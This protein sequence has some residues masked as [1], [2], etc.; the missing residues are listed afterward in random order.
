MVEFDTPDVLLSNGASCFAA[1]VEQTG[2][3]EAE[4]L[5][6]LTKRKRMA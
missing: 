3:A 6:L 5:Q 4:Y 1:L 2:A